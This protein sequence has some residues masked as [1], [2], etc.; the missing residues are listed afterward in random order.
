[1]YKKCEQVFYTNSHRLLRN[2][3]LWTVAVMQCNAYVASLLK[4]TGLESRSIMFVV[5]L[6]IH[7]ISL[8]VL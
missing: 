1:M 4:Y 7:V 3:P 8:H 2:Q 5:S 6:V